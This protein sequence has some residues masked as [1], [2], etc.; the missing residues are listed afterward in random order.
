M[1]TLNA[2][3]G[4]CLSM[5]LLFSQR[6]FSQT[7]DHLKYYILYD[8][9]G[10]VS[11]VDKKENLRKFMAALIERSNGNIKTASDVEIY[12]FGEESFISDGNIVDYNS[13]GKRGDTQGQAN[14]KI[15][16]FTNLQNNKNQKYTNIHT[17]LDKVIDAINKSKDVTSSGVF[18]FTDG[19]LSFGDFTLEGA[20]IIKKGITKEGYFAYLNSL[21]DQIK[22]LTHKPVF[23]V[24]TS[25]EPVNN[26]YPGL[27][28]LL[29]R[30]KMDSDTS[31][32]LNDSTVF[33][34]KNTQ[35][36]NGAL[37]NDKVTLAYEDFIERANN[38]IIKSDPPLADKSDN[39]IDKALIIQN[40]ASLKAPM[41]KLDKNK[42]ILLENE[43]PDLANILKYINE[44]GLLKKE[45]I[46]KIRKF[47]EETSISKLKE[48]EMKAEA[49]IVSL[50]DK[51]SKILSGINQISFN[52]KA[53]SSV[54]PTYTNV[55]SE[56]NGLRSLE[57]N[58]ILGISD[59]IIDRAKQEAVYAF[60]ENIKKAVFDPNL[61]VKQIFPEVNNKLIDSSNYYDMS[62]LKEAFR[63]DINSLPDNIMASS[64]IYKGTEELTSMVM[65][66]KLFKNI[67]DQGNL[68][69]AFRDLADDIKALPIKDK[70]TY[71]AA[72]FMTNIIGYLTTN[73]IAELY[74]DK[75]KFGQLATLLIALS[76]DDQTLDKIT[77]IKVDNSGQ[78]IGDIYRQ[79]ENIKSQVKIFNNRK[80]PLA[81]FDQFRKMQADATIEILSRSS[82]LMLKGFDVLQKLN[83]IDA[84]NETFDY[85]TLQTDIKKCIEAYFLIK[86]KDYTQA[87]MLLAPFITKSI[88][89]K[90][91]YD[92]MVVNV[93]EINSK[94]E[95]YKSGLRKEN[96]S[97]TA[98]KKELKNILATKPVDESK[99]QA[100]E[101]QVAIYT[102]I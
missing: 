5:I 3:L 88:F 83:Y 57:Q 89:N 20:D 2:A 9:S 68:E 84:T 61:Y 33:W 28:A 94:I 11:K 27:Q 8:R 6:S 32:L 30:N 35:A 58:V 102:T 15:D 29:V 37:K 14:I 62:L 40:I 76:I 101:Q 55:V 22:T 97:L 92:K 81:D 39:R 65:F 56:N 96:T 4:L 71:D 47:V 44:Q 87:T 54:K 18:I 75:Q 49:E 73:D 36:Y 19:Q 43:V 99:K 79:Y 50:S 82:D 17:A 26:Y 42:F 59:Y 23:L 95:R 16:D 69:Y 45:D 74:K 53:F 80:D 48:V 91:A 64:E 67:S 70:R 93:N 34:L 10:S 77:T 98:A 46:Q 24:Q 100:L 41:E 66:L 7:T 12:S 38:M 13:A 31:K 25:Y 78:L 1:K 51:S 90:E 86:E 52:H 21:I 63:R 72:I 60:M 85:L